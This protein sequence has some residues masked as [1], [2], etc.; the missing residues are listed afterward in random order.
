MNA[1]D[2]VTVQISVAAKWRAGGTVTMPRSEY[3]RYCDALDNTR[4]FKTES[5]AEEI[6]GLVGGD[7]YRH[8]DVDR[9]EV[10]DFELLSGGAK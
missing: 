1:D 7:A 9:Y 4:G 2:M 5:L 8:A 3:D 6:I 10:E